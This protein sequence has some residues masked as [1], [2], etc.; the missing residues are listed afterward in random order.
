[1]P[2]F[3]EDSDELMHAGDSLQYGIRLSPRRRTLCLQVR[4]DGGVRILAPLRTP[5]GAIRAF[6]T[7]RMA[8][9]RA[10]Q[11]WFAARPAPPQPLPLTQGTTVPLLDDKLVLDI[12][13]R[14]GRVHIV[15][16]GDALRF[17]GPV[18]HL[19]VALAR[20]YRAR[21]AEYVARRVQAFAP[22]VGR[23]P[24]KIAIRDQRT[25]WGSCSA[26]GTISINWRLMLAPA[27]LID[28]VI[29]HELCHLLH[30]NHGPRFWQA[31]ARVVPDYASRRAQLNARAATLY[32][33]ASNIAT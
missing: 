13:A 3:A 1:M 31:V 20:W 10:K 29:V 17:E 14:A 4:A 25:R 15:R 21:A 32:L 22:H 5:R 2:R 16:D 11:K 12:H 6:V 19:Q 8:W 28:Y 24:T 27:Q 33:G 23:A 26:R 9:I 18:V 30:A 7:D